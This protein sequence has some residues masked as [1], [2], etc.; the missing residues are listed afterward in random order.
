LR[1]ST[2][3]GRMIAKSDSLTFEEQFLEKVRYF[4]S[5]EGPLSKAKNFEYRPQQAQMA[6]E[7]ARALLDGAN[8]II[9][10]PT[11]IGKSFAY[12]Y[13]AILFAV[14]FRKKAIVSTFTINLQ[15][16]LV[17]KDLPVLKKL[18]PEGFTVAILKGRNNYLCTRRLH[19]ALLNAR[20]LFTGPEEAELM[21]IHEWSK[22]TEDGS[23]SDLSPEPD[24][25]VWEMVRSER[26]LCSPRLCGRGSE[27]AKHN[28]LC[29]YQKAREKFLLAD[30]LVLNHMLFFSLFG[31]L[32]EDTPSTGGFI[33][34]NDF[35][36][37]DEAHQVPSVASEM[38]GAS[39]SNGQIMYTLHR[40]WN[41]KTEKGLLSLL[42]GSR[43]IKL[44][45]ELLESVGEFFKVVEE[46]CD[47]MHTRLESRLLGETAG[48]HSGKKGAWTE[49]RIRRPDFVPDNISLPIQRLRE[50]IGGLIKSCEDQ[51]LG[52]ELAEINRRLGEFR[53]QIVTFL[54]QSLPDYVYWVERSGKLQRTIAL[55]FAPIDIA[56]FLR[57]ALFESGSSVIM[58]SGTLSIP[59]SL[60][61]EIK[62]RYITSRDGNKQDSPSFEGPCQLSYFA[63]RVGG[64]SARLVRLDSPFDY[65]KQMKVYVV[66]KSDPRSSPFVDELE[67]WVRHFVELTGGKAFVL[68]TNVSLMHE[69]AQ[70]LAPYFRER[71]IE[72]YVQGTGLPRST[73]LERFK[74]DGN[75]VLFGVDSF[76]QGVDVPGEA[77]SNVIITKLPFAVPDHPL[78]Q[79]KIEAIE[80]R[81]G[82]A[83]IEFTLPE[84]VLKFKQGVGRLIRTKNDRG[85]VVVLDGRILTRSY[86]R[87]FLEAIPQCPIEIV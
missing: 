42:R 31:G 76:W 50:E 10:A 5:N 19:H 48:D 62:K 85:I 63:S 44:V 21:R 52:G 27:F 82:D 47:E 9:E 66:G 28:P 33:F 17:C 29:F 36:I 6:E 49:I 30:I 65:Q 4:F 58:T 39:V 16:Q 23:L 87:I 13:P 55:N 46:A 3:I 64:K 77:L 1:L 81:G 18:I 75:S 25:A 79:A 71:G 40:L 57:T 60:A 78:I 26:G 83:F 69:V 41:P 24:P 8:L 73:M 67:Y 45:T 37:F 20:G 15:E 34:S 53:E 72:C 12:L 51:D 2:L 84:A 38:V 80:A 22:V 7:V 35:V 54:K 59:E 11:G 70:R 43:A 86:G 74:Q 32:D 56:E 14:K 68:F 61:R